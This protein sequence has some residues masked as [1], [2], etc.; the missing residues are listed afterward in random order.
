MNIAEPTNKAI[1]IIGKYLTNTVLGDI[2]S[3]TFNKG[4]NLQYSQSLYW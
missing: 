2:A 3:R 1:E 4:E